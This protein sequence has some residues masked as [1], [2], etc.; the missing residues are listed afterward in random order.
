MNGAES[1][2]SIVS[3]HQVKAGSL[4]GLIGVVDRRADGNRGRCARIGGAQ[5]ESQT[6]ESVG[7]QVVLVHYG[8][9]AGRSLGSLQIRAVS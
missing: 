1:H 9:I 2:L 6:L 7:S 5:V 8:H 4:A 3:V